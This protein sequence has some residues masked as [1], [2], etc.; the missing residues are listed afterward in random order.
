MTMDGAPSRDAMRGDVLDGDRCVKRILLPPHSNPVAGLADLR[1]RTVGRPRQRGLGVAILQGLDRG[2]Q[3]DL[4]AWRLADFNDASWS[5]GRGPFYY[6][7]GSGFSGNTALTDMRGSYTCVFLRRAFSVTNPSGVQELTLY[8]QADDGC[9]VWLNRHPTWPGSTMPDGEPLYSW[10]SL[11]A[12]GEPNVD[13][14]VITKRRVSAP[15]R[16]QHPGRPS[17]QL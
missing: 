3:P 5:I 9:L 10:T 15:D 14:V 17:L 4:G 7:D 16:R 13:T 2:V 12:A 6:E 1:S 11:P 8:L